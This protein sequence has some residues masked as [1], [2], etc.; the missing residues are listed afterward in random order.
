MLHIFAKISILI[1]CLSVSI[2]SA[3]AAAMCTEKITKTILHA[4]GQVYF[5]TDQ[6]CSANWCQINWGAPTNNKNGLAALLSAKL[7]ERPLSFYWP[8]ITSCD[9]KNVTYASPEYLEIP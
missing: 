6:T 2:E 3:N 1:A 8:N 7:A 9:E 4:N 5:Q